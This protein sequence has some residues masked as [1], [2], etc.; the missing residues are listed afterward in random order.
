[1]AREFR[2][3]L[4]N[5]G[6]KFFEHPIE[7]VDCH[8]VDPMG[9]Y[10]FR[11]SHAFQDVVS[12][13]FSDYLKSSGLTIGELLDLDKYEKWKRQNVLEGDVEGMSIYLSDLWW[14][15]YDEDEDEDPLDGWY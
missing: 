3:H 13:T 4:R 7:W 6:F 11:G 9:M 14:I 8:E 1:M 15:R 12:K 10:C 2:R 5:D